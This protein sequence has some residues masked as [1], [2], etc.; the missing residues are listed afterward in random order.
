MGVRNWLAASIALAAL[1][2]AAQT[3]QAA[4]I[5]S[6]CQYGDQEATYIGSYNPTIPDLGTFGHTDLGP[7]AGANTAFV[8]Y[9]VFD[10]DP[11][12]SVSISAD[13]TM[14]TGIADFAAQLF[15][16][17]GSTCASS[18]CSNVV[19]GA[20]IASD[21]SVGNERRWEMIVDDLPAGRYVIQVT[22]TTN[23]RATSTYTGQLAFST[24]PIPGPGTL[25]LLGLGLLGMCPLLRR[26]LRE[27]RL[28]A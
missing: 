4:V 22:G 16:D 2:L 14:L 6:G 28:E 1:T 3:A 27:V 7:D 25:A 10:V 5:C 21:A 23:N 15:A 24:I 8:D 9:W 13:F 26:G 17:G 20:L 12:G 18:D 11:A 19:T